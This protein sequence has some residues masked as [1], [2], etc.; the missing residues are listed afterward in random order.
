MNIGERIKSRRKELNMSQ[1][2]LAKKVGYKSR[3]SINKIELSRSLPL[4]KV[5]VMATALDCPPSYLM[6]WEP[7]EQAE[8]IKGH[9]KAKI[10]SLADTSNAFID[11]IQNDKVFMEHIRALFELTEKYRLKVYGYIQDQKE[12]EKQQSGEIST[13]LREA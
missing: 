6:G 7:E 8:E 5:E 13:K 10:A 11:A 1:D 12:L 9:M 2:E 3:S 4:S